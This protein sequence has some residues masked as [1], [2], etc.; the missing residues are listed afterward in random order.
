MILEEPYILMHPSLLL[1][2]FLGRQELIDRILNLKGS[3][4]RDREAEQL[5][6]H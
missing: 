5:I 4:L 3:V 6:N 2:I 1:N